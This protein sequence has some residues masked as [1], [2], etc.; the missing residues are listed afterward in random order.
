MYP[1]GFK[2]NQVLK[3]NMDNETK[4]L[5]DQIKAYQPFNEQEEKDKELFI[6]WLESGVDVFER[7][8]EI[9]HFTATSWIVNK[10]RTKVLMAYH[11][12]FKTFAWLGGHADGEKDMLKV[13]IKE[14]QEESGIKNYKILSEDIFTLETLCVRGHEK[15]G[16]YVPTHLHL[17]V[18]YLFEVDENEPIRI[19]EDENSAIGWIDVDKI[20]DTCKKESWVVERIYS[21]ITQKI[22]TGN[23]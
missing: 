11:N 15:R 19:K 3:S 18:T 6:M 16:K 17:N 12:L 4:N 23:Y 20:K 1:Y 9:A 10:S 7:T 8:N 21:K 22:N 14:M 13:A 5:L 2:L